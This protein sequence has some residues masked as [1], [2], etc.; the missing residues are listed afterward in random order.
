MCQVKQ[1]EQTF[2]DSRRL[3]NISSR[4]LCLLDYPDK[5]RRLKFFNIY[6][7]GYLYSYLINLNYMLRKLP[8]CINIDGKLNYSFSGLKRT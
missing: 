8:N 5:V 3:I 6:K 4:I 7:I 2:R 1:K